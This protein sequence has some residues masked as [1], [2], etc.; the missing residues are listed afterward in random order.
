MKGRL[1]SSFS[2][3]AGKIEVVGIPS[4]LEGARHLA[5]SDRYEFQYWVCTLI[6]ALPPAGANQKGADRGIDGIINFFDLTGKPQQ[7]IVSVKSG[8]VQVKDVRELI[9]VV[10]KREAALGLFITL[11]SPTGPLT[12][13]AVSAGFFQAGGGVQ[14]PKIQVLT[15]EQ[16]LHGQKPQ[17]PAQVGGVANVALKQAQEI[18]VE[19]QT[20][21][22]Y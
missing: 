17:Y 16:L 14:Y 8:H 15:V 11:E 12:T 21:F 7:I 3:L 1:E 20:A 2:D 9:Q 10:N 4:D 18:E 5:H 22:A 6:G 13:E 19:E